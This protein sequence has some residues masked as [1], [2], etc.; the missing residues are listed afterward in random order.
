MSSSQDHVDIPTE[1]ELCNVQH[2]AE[3]LLE[4]ERGFENNKAYYAIYV[5][6]GIE[7]ILNIKKRKRGKIF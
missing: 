7:E 4:I 6:E 1:K 2:A 3:R 5:K